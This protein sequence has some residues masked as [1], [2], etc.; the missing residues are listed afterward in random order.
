MILD[1]ETIKLDFASIVIRN[2]KN[3]ISKESSFEV[4]CY[5]VL[6]KNANIERHNSTIEITGTQIFI[7]K[8][9]NKKE[10]SFNFLNTL[11]IKD[12]DFEICSVKTFP[13]SKS[14]QIVKLSEG[15][16]L[17]KKTNPFKLISTV[18]YDIIIN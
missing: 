17:L 10:V 2:E 9:Y 1:Y 16:Y 6:L 8:T 3:V 11:E 14:K 18:P 5:D 12:N 7:H 4:Y 15:I 13:W